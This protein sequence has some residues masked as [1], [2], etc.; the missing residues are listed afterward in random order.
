[1]LLEMFLEMAGNPEGDLHLSHGNCIV[2]VAA[3]AIN[4]TVSSENRCLVGNVVARLV[5]NVNGDGM[6][7]IPLH[8]NACEG[9]LDGKDFGFSLAGAI[10]VPSS[11]MACDSVCSGWHQSIHAIVKGVPQFYCYDG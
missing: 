9:Y 6:N 1:M 10:H 11:F 7:T 2:I 8:A 5:G 3:H 4:G